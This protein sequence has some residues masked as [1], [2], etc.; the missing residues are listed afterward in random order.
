MK[1]N[2]NSILN[3]TNILFLFL[4][5]FVIFSGVY[6]QLRFHINILPDEP[7]LSHET[8]NIL[9]IISS[10]LFTGLAVYHLFKHKR[11][12]K[13]VLSKRLLRQNRATLMLTFMLILSAISALLALIAR[14]NIT[15]ALYRNHMIEIHDK[16]SILFL[17][18]LT[19]HLI[20]KRK[21]F[22]IKA[23]FDKL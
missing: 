2:N 20:R 8:W 4:T 1:T 17:I 12:Y 18:L 7:I 14:I 6:I 5:L 22:R 19:V 15:T 23:I 21:N 11:W 9:H 16:I 10:L 13:A 3:Y